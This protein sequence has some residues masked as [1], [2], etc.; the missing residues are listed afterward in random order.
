MI[1]AYTDGSIEINPG[2][3]GGWAA[4]LLYPEGRRTEL[5]GGEMISTN[6]RI[7]MLAALEVLKILPSGSQITLWSDSE[8][9]V[10]G[11]QY[12]VDR[13]KREGVLQSKAN[14]DRWTALVTEAARHKVTWRWIR[15]HSGHEH[16]ERADFLADVA[17]LRQ[18]E[19]DP[20]YMEVLR[21]PFSFGRL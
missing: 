16:N 9:L 6:N 3:P 7:E 21:S 12:R 15:G 8:Y 17:R 11:M 14:P 2:G 1:N 18:E 10:K 5:T 20:Q 4:V 13:W 19:L